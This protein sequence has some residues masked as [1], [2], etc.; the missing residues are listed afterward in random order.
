MKTACTLDSNKAA[1]IDSRLKKW[2]PELGFVRRATYASV[3]QDKYVDA[4]V[5]L[6]VQKSSTVPLFFQHEPPRMPW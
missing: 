6:L 4:V 5:I 3:R 2:M 1:L